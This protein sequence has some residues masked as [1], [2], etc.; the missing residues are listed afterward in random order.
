[1]S[2]PFL[3]SRPN[4]LS[5]I[6]Q[7]M[8]EEEFSAGSTVRGGQ[9]RGSQQS[10]LDDLAQ[11]A[12]TTHG[13]FFQRLAWFPNQLATDGKPLE[14]LEIKGSVA[15]AENGLQPVGRGDDGPRV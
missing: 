13:L 12:C 7:G 11:S 9:D 3:R 10:R 8:Y 15:Q 14:L 4:P 6:S 5:D 1:M 2:D